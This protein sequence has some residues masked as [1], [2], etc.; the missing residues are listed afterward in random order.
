[1]TLLGF[2][3][4]LIAPKKEEGTSSAGHRY[5]RRWQD[6][7][8]VEDYAMFD[9]QAPW[10]YEYDNDP[11]KRVRTGAMP[12]DND[13]LRF[14]VNRLLARASQSGIVE[15]KSSAEGQRTLTFR[16]PGTSVSIPLKH[17]TRG[18]I[19]VSLV[20]KKSSRYGGWFD[21]GANRIVLI[22]NSEEATEG[23]TLERYLQRILAHEWTHSLD[24]GL[25]KTVKHQ[26]AE[27]LKNRK[28][29][30]KNPTRRPEPRPGFNEYINRKEEVAAR[31]QEIVFSLSTKEA[32]AKLRKDA[33]S[34]ANRDKPFH[35]RSG[36]GMVQR[37]L[38]V[39]PVLQ[40]ADRSP[41]TEANKKRIWR[42]V[43]DTYDA[44]MDNKIKPLE[45]YL[46]PKR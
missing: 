35:F 17:P 27:D 38:L 20:S 26:Q 30:Q 19:E 23:K 25:T 15:S 3:R 44:I 24:R 4:N 2:L 34:A 36:A 22:A 11:K 16:K 33:E 6:P 37:V 5:S 13:Q 21:P 9:Q 31:I 8:D 41:Y 7:Q 14:T 40:E 32:V 29:L 39:S 42:A 45:G 1:M 46:G 43:A 28:I 18:E 12:I 10:H